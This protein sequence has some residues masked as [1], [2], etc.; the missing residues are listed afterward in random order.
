MSVNYQVHETAIIDPGSQIGE[1]SR[2][3]HWV[4]ICGGAKIGKNVSLGQNVFVGKKI[5]I[6]GQCKIVCGVTIGEYTLF[7]AGVVFSN[8]V[9]PNDST[10]G[11]PARQFG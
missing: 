11:V 8:N 6:G 5:T 2:I 4:H 1:N 9:R 3:R 10:V 7:S